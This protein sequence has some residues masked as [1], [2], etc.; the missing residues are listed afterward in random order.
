MR[1]EKKKIAKIISLVGTSRP[2]IARLGKRRF[3][4]PKPVL[5]DHKLSSKPVFINHICKSESSCEVCKSYCNILQNWRY[6]T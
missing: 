3:D 2:E 1:G 4:L 5:A 6:S